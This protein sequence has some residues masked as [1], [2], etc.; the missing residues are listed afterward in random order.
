MKN[1]FKFLEIFILCSIDH[2]AVD[3]RSIDDVSLVE[4]KWRAPERERHS[5]YDEFFF[6]SSVMVLLLTQ[7]LLAA[8]MNSHRE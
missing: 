8:L 3:Q 6:I 2:R 4:H 7:C 1:S 5:D